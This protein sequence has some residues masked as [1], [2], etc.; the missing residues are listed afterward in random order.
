MI[1]LYNRSTDSDKLYFTLFID[2]GEAASENVADM[3]I[4]NSKA[5]DEMFA[6][7]KIFY[8]DMPQIVNN[9]VNAEILVSTYNMQNMF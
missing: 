8:F 2:I 6:F 1:I 5:S 9:I 7:L 3:L 4:M